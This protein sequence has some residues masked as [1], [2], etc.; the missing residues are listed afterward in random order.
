M[1]PGS[2]DIRTAPTRNLEQ[3]GCGQPCAAAHLRTRSGCRPGS[4]LTTVARS[5]PDED[6]FN[7]VDG[8]RPDYAVFD[9]AM[10][11]AKTTFLAPMV[12]AGRFAQVD[13]KLVSK[14]E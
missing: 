8:A 9:A 7:D 6:G 11:Q 5:E 2:R 3:G 10:E 14:P 13:W 12:E 1:P 4:R